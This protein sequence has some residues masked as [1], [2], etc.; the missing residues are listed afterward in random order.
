MAK[1]R[2]DENVEQNRGVAVEMM[3]LLQRFC[4]LHAA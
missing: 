4:D 2:R 1:I 3:E